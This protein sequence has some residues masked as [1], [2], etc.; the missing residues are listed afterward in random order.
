MEAIGT[1]QS[2]G[3]GASSYNTVYPVTYRRGWAG[4]FSGENQTKALRRALTELNR[5]GL[6]V[7]SITPD[8]WSFWKTLGSIL[9]A[10]V[11]LGFVVRGPNLLLLT[12]PIATPARAG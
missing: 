6:G 5:R 7:A 1:S 3:E 12:E 9:L 11:T 8:R 2:Q 10:A 4:L